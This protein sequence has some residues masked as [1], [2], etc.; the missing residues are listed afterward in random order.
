VDTTLWLLALP[1]GG[2]LLWA[3]WRAHVGRRLWHRLVDADLLEHLA[4]PVQESSARIA[5]G[6][7]TLVLVL[8][9][10]ALAGP[11]WRTHANAQQRQPGARIVV[12]DLSPSMDAI[13][14]APSR[15]RRAR[16]ATGALLRGAAGEQLGVVVFGA[17]AFSVAPLTSDPATLVHLL[18]GAT[19]TTVPRAG[20]RPDLGLE[21]AR[22]LLKQAG[23]ERGDVIL[24]ADSAGDARTLDAARTLARAGFPVSVLAVGT[25]HGGPI[26]VATGAFARTEAGE[27]RIAKAELA[28]LEDVAQAGAG[29]FEVLRAP[30]EMPNFARERREGLEP[31]RPA[32]G[33]RE[34]THDGGAWLAL[35]ALPF[36]ALLFRRGWL[37]GL[38]ALAL[39]PALVPQEAQALDWESLWRRPD[40]QA[41]AAFA[42]ASRATPHAFWAGSTPIRRGTR[43]CCI[44]AA[45]SPRPRR[46]SRRA[47]PR[48]RITT[49]AMRSLS[50]AT[51][52]ERSRP[53]T[54]RLRAILRCRMRSST[55]RWCARRLPRSRWSRRTAT[56]DRRSGSRSSRLRGPE[57][58][59]GARAPE[60]ADAS[61]RRSQIDEFGSL[62]PLP[63]WTQRAQGKEQDGSQAADR[64]SPEERERLEGLLSQV[65]DDPG[66]LLASR[67]AQQLRSR[68]TPHPDT[69][70]RW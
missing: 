8:A 25:A 1:A 34:A 20:S 27:I 33:M 69:G 52:K 11:V 46:S 32:S 66:S 12:L 63:S 47:T 56:R 10:C 59:A 55:V 64:L 53:T 31:V 70:A 2:A 17:D 50:M 43:C 21:M 68:G 35:L 30:G 37:G 29:R 28:G 58:R 9:V 57:P 41:A 48:S 67:F 45:T 62:P 22:A 51:S 4:G 13:D 26:P 54:P 60:Q 19:T 39:L 16:D 15:L 7:S 42:R 6:I 65:P 38:A 44:A 3:W 14:V 18:A 61:G 24:V 5:L 36:A 49:A 40:Q 23:I